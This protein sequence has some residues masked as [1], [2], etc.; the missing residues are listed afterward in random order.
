M[1]LCQNS[2][3][4]TFGK[5]YTALTFQKNL[6]KFQVK[7]LRH[8]TWHVSFHVERGLR[9]RWDGGGCSLACEDGGGG[10]GSTFYSHPVVLL[11]FSVEISSRAPIPHPG[12]G[13]FT[14]AQRAEMTAAE[15]FLTSCV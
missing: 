9:Q 2:S 13:H 3:T 1:K 15:R 11:L 7:N 6:I 14:V 8:S 4:Y 5:R 12:P 10:A